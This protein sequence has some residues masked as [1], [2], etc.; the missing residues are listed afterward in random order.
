[1]AGKMDLSID[2]INTKISRLNCCFSSVH[3]DIVVVILYDSLNHFARL[4]ANHDNDHI[5]VKDFESESQK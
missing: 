4:W 2:H 3:V 1:M 5:P